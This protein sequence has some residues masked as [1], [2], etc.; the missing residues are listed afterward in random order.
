M[1]T[2]IMSRIATRL[3]W[4]AVSS[5]A[6]DACGGASESTNT[7]TV[8]TLTAITISL[9]PATIQVGQTAT[10]SA[11][12]TDQNGKSVNLSGTSWSSGSPSVATVTPGGIISAVAAGQA[13]ISATT[14]GKVGSATLT[15]QPFAAA[16]DFAITG[17]QFTQ[18]VQTADGSIPMV[19][20][21]NAA[22]VNVLIRGA[23]PAPVRMQVVLRIFDAA[24]AVVR[25]DT[26]LTTGMIGPTPTYASPSA[27]FLV[28]LAVL[29]AG[30]R[31]QVIRDPK[32][33][34]PD[35]STATDVFPRTGTA[36][37]AVVDVPPLNIRFVPITLS[38]YGNATGAV[39]TDNLKQYLWTL[40]SVHPLGVVNAHVGP[41]LV[42]N[43]SFGTAP[44]GG[45]AGFWQQVI[46]E[47]DLARIADPVEPDA[48][49][50]G[51]VVPPR[52]FNYTVF[53]GMS[54]VPTSS[55]NTG[56]G[57]RTS[58]SVQLNWFFDPTKARDLVAHELGHT[59]GRSHAPCGSAVPPLDP[60]FPTVGG[61][62]EQVGHDVYGWANGL[63]SSA[64]T[65][66]ETTG[67]VMGYCNPVWASAYTYRAVMA[68]RGSTVLAS[69]TREPL[70]RVL[71]VRGSVVNG[72]SISLEPAFVLDGRPTPPATSGE[73]TLEGLDETGR[74]LFAVPF[75]P[76]VLDHAPDVSPF[77]I[78]LPSNATLE[79]RLASIVV[80]GAAG[81]HRIDRAV[82]PLRSEANDNVKQILERSSDGS[83]TAQCDEGGSRGIAVLGQNGA[84]LGSA[85]KASMRFVA[86]LGASLSIICSDGVRTSRTAAVAP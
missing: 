36:P 45:A 12:G 23:A 9:A 65:I 21:G 20:S 26:A 16:G 27:Q 77:T 22:V 71:I 1:N 17:A 82:P 86:P 29:K 10:A 78:A 61:T 70:T 58:A 14:G 31:W 60:T 33:I 2:L 56:P 46:A 76:F 73:Y 15:V 24:G 85:A 5:L 32:R 42:T 83:L 41:P 62:I 18:G 75:T 64:E 44:S 4:C 48:N 67:D 59:F 79:S 3:V 54:Y 55:S 6:V 80:R 50:Y 25:T 63:A 68:F 13:T 11:T 39:S 37:L 72:R 40:R 49:W 19:L 53:G 35:D 47:L 57:T 7:T 38:A 51:V 52:G 28:A 84:V 8:S 66:P 69:R 30:M 81:M 43:A 34:A 74:S